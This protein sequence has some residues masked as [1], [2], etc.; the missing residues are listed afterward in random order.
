MPPLTAFSIELTALIIFLI[1]FIFFVKGLLGYVYG[2]S[3][4]IAFFCRPHRRVEVNS[5]HET[6]IGKSIKTILGSLLF[7][8]IALIIYFTVTNFVS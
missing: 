4:M 2:C 3:A 6:I 8:A 7:M 1:A 5:E